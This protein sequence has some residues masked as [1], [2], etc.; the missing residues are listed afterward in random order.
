M[1]I[2]ALAIDGDGRLRRR[3]S[4]P[5]IFFWRVAMLINKYRKTIAAGDHFYDTLR[6][7]YIDI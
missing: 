5:L 1:P 6:R 2:S 4:I 3:R 7:A